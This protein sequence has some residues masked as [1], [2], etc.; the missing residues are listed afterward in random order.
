LAGYGIHALHGNREGAA[1]DRATTIYIIQ[2]DPHV[3]REAFDATSR[4]RPFLGDPG[5]SQVSILSNGDRTD[6]DAT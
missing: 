3:L 4:E 1:D 6:A 5:D 2:S